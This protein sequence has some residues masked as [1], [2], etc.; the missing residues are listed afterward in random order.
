[1]VLQHF[2]NYLCAS[3][4]EL[5]TSEVIGSGWELGSSEHPR[6]GGTD[7]VNGLA[8][9]STPYLPERRAIIQAVGKRDRAIQMF[10]SKFLFSATQRASGASGAAAC[11]S[12]CPVHCP[13]C[14]FLFSLV[15]RL[16]QDAPLISSPPP[17]PLLPIPPSP[18]PSLFLSPPLPP[19]PF[20]LSSSDP[21]P[22]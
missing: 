22:R 2:K 6:G 19:S 7:R 12:P 18:L 3:K 4:N 1:M 20:P 13:S 15:A 8:T 10:S 5:L 17:S 9:V 14:C 11:L 21:G 16:Y